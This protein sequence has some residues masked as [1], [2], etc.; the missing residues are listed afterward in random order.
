MSP[1]THCCGKVL[2]CIPSSACCGLVR[3]HGAQH[4]Q[5]LVA[6]GL[7]TYLS[8]HA[9]EESL[10]ELNYEGEPLKLSHFLQNG[11]RRPVLVRKSCQIPSILYP[12]LYSLALA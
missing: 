9:A 4:L 10:P 7:L 1:G 5:T 8:A 11:V 6:R 3:S 12:V 2:H